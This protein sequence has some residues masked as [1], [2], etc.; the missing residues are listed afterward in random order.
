MTIAFAMLL[1]GSLLIY[2][3]WKDLSVFS[4]LRGDNTKPKATAA[5]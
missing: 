2:G 1:F 5:S 4:L 3:G